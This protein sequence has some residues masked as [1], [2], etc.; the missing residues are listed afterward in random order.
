MNSDWPAVVCLGEVLIDFVARDAELPLQQATTFHKAAGG[1]PA[2]VAAALARLGITVAFIGKVGGDAFGQSLRETLATEGVAVRGL[3]EAPTARTA[4]AF[5]GSDGHGGREFVFYHRGMADTLLRP[6]EVDR[7]LIAHARIF[8]FGSVTLATEPSRAATTAAAQMAH[9]A[10]CL[11]SF[12][13]NVRLEV[14]DS[15]RH[16]R[17]SMIA[18]LRLVDVVKV[19]SDEL[20]FLTGT[21][22]PAEACHILRDHGPTLAI[23]TLGGGGC[24][25]QTA[26]AS[27]HVPGIHVESVDSLGAGDAFVAGVLACL[28]AYADRNDVCAEATLVPALRF[29][30][31]VGA[32]TTTRYGAIPALP[33]RPQVEALLEAPTSV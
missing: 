32:I 9:E 12:D 7:E 19:S 22:D 24:Y 11:V 23:V 33:T 28:S 6:E 5:V 15:P 29:A 1:A 4:L 14:W 2:N 3:V 25:Y 13:P 10:G 20:A 31:A 18:A 27:G 21:A 30:N 17:D 26:S 16:A 8:H